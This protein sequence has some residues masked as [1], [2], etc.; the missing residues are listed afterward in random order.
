MI[1]LHHFQKSDGSSW[2]Y[3]ELLFDKSSLKPRIH[4]VEQVDPFVDASKL[5]NFSRLMMIFTS[6][7][8]IEAR[9]KGGEKGEKKKRICEAQYTLC[10]VESESQIAS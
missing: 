4:I 6:G 7:V 9:K 10:W 5:M 2:L 3:V 1:S 8:L